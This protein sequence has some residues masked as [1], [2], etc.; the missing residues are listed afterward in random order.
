MI[1]KLT[2][3]LLGLALSLSLVATAGAH[4]SLPQ[5]ARIDAAQAA[6][7]IDADQSLFYRFQYVFDGD[8]L[9]AEYQPDERTPIRCATPL[10]IEFNAH[11]AELRPE[12][13]QAIDTWLSPPAGDKA[14]YV[15]PGGFFRLT[16]L[17]TGTNRVPTTDTTPANGIPDFVERVASYLDTSW[18]TE[19]TTL[20]FTGPLHSPYYAIS[21][22]NQ[23]GAYGFTTISGGTTNIVL[24][25]DYVG[26][27]AND[28]PDGDVLGAAKVT[29][30]HEFK[31]ASQYR[32]SLWS[33]GGWVELD[34]TWAEDTVFDATND[35]YN[36]L[37]S[38]NGISTPGTSLDGGST[39]TGSYEDAI[40][41]YWMSETWG[42]S[43]IVNLWTWRASHQSEPMLTTYNTI[44][45]TVGSSIQA[46]Y[47]VYSAWCYATGTR[48]ITGLGFGEAAAYPTSQ[49]TVVSTYPTS[50]SG[51][52]S[53]LSAK[54]FHCNGFTAGEPGWLRINFNGDNTQPMSLMAVIQRNDGTGLIQSI[55]LD[56]NHDCDT[57]LSVALADLAR[58]GL[59]VVNAGTTGDNKSYALTVSRE[60]P[61][62]TA[63]LSAAGVT[64]TMNTNALGSETVDLS[65]TGMAGSQLHYSTYV[66]GQ[67]PSAKALATLIKA[68][69]QPAASQKTLGKLEHAEPMLS[70]SYAGACVFGNNDTGNIQGHYNS[71]VTGIESYATY[72]NP[73]DYTCSCNPG[74]NVRA[75][76]MVLYLPVGAAV[77]GRVSLAAAADP[78]VG[79]GAILETSAIT[80]FAA[81]ATAGYYNLEVPCNFACQ[82]LSG[83]Y[84]LVFELVNALTGVGLPVDTTPQGCVNFNDYGSGYED[85]VDFDGFAGD[86]LIWGDIDCCGTP[87]PSSQVLTPNGGEVLAV[88]SPLSV[89]WN[90]LV[91][92]DVMVELSRDGGTNWE[93]LSISTPNDGAET[94]TVTGPA[95][96]NC[97]VRV[98]S[99]D[100]T[101]TDVSNAPFWIYQTVPWLTAAPT[102]GT[103]P[104]GASQPLALSFDTTGMA[105]G[106]YD[107]WVVIMHNAAGSPSVLPVDLTVQTYVAGTTV[108]NV[109]ALRGNAPNPFNP[110]TRLS[111]SLVKGG[112][113]VVDVLDL[114]GHVVRT[115]LS[116]TVAAGEQSVVWDGRD[117]AGHAVASGTYLAR[118]RAEGQVAT[119][120]MVLT[121]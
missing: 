69:A 38:G 72:I 10:I 117:D 6:G 92:T 45:G 25:N 110:S 3:V 75:I 82:D 17:T 28:D 5:F 59:V 73:A 83:Q 105:G 74:F 116:G 79:P 60:L 13:V 104:Q 1:R 34:G 113:A 43:L 85:L 8:K 26:F 46:G 71:W 119:H 20:G 81:A 101:V 21:F 67:A 14:T 56:A 15:S 87:N 37:Y 40:F 11:R 84:F 102:T 35:Y 77:Q 86:I 89:T 63:T 30:A 22:Q 48:A 96:Q 33:E 88:G 53:H 78:C 68:D 32:T 115:L 44:L 51:T 16:Y 61:P 62:A 49:A 24:E 7:L 114:Q 91:L 100:G 111:F 36:Y 23:S 2:L 18:N 90:A 39:G 52:L 55:P 121:K 99:L 95:S 94:F 66:M 97:L 103:L 41:E 50:N 27:P 29:C 107:A 9:P 108:P 109:F 54:Y 4:Q 42:N 65:N 112:A 76:H 118:L 19:I 12:T 80:T 58:V 64:K 70:P 106:N 120:K 57:Q 98:G 93:V 31:H 47:P